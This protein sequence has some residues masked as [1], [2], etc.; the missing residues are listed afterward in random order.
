MGFCSIG[1][2]IPLS[3]CLSFLVLFSGSLFRVGR[4]VTKPQL[5]SNDPNQLFDTA[6][7]QDRAHGD[8]DT[9]L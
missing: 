9:E 8:I 6:P 3:I 1:S 7:T 2:L 4:F 5:R